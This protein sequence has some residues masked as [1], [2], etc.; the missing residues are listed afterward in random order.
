MSS[1]WSGSSYKSCLIW[2]CSVWK[3][4]KRRLYGIKGW[5]TS[6]QPPG[7][8]HFYTIVQWNWRCFT[9]SFKN[10]QTKP[11]PEVIKLFSCSTQLSKKF[12]LVIKTKIQTNEEA[13]CLKSIRSGVVFIML[14]NVVGILTFMSRVNFVLSWVE[15]ENSFITYGPVLNVSFVYVSAY[16]SS[17]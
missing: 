16:C 17:I 5:T 8:L 9:A 13:Y 4:V 12:Q 6:V 2:V 3:S 7:L 15:H 11:G 1:P 10:D 14:I